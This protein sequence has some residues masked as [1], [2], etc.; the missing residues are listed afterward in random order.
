MKIRLG[1]GVENGHPASDIVYDADYQSVLTKATALGYTLPTLAN[2]IQQNTLML[3]LKSSGVWAKLDVFYMFANTGSKEFATLNWKNPNSNQATVVGSMT[4]NN[5]G[6]IGA[7]NSYLNTNFNPT[8]G[9]PLFSQNDAMIGC[10]K[11]THDATTGKFLWGNSGGSS[12]VRSVSDYDQR[13]NA[14]ASLGGSNPT[15]T[16]TNTGLLILNRTSS[17]QM[18]HSVISTTISDKTNLSA[19]ANSTTLVNANYSIFTYAGTVG[20]AYLGQLSSWFIG[21]SIVSETPAFY[22][23]MN[24]YI[25]NF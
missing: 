23:A 22:T 1:I 21:K 5:A 20:G 13:L 3:A 2:Q 25:S 10:W 4:W 12:Y 19:T 9:T 18:Y 15:F 7:A 17:T 16:T 14:S 8:T 24:T 11:K 6:Y